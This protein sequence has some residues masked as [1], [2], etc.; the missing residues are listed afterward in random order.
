MLR[1][2]RRI[3]SALAPDARQR[4]LERLVITIIGAAI[5]KDKSL[6]LIIEDIQWMNTQ[7]MKLLLA[8]SIQIV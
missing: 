1:C 4:N 6:L 7:S 2:L 3:T 5:A 8:V